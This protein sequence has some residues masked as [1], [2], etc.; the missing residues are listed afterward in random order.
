MKQKSSKQNLKLPHS[1]NNFNILWRKVIR[2]CAHRHIVTQN[3]ARIL[4]Q[5]HINWFYVTINIAIQDVLYP[6]LMCKCTFP[7]SNWQI[8]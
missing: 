6:Y 3:P 1:I 5:V 4:K 2:L 7:E 8:N